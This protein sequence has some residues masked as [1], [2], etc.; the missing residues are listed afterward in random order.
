MELCNSFQA[1]FANFTTVFSASSFALWTAL[2]AG[3]IQSHRHRFVSDLI[4]SSDSTRNGTWT[5]YYHFFSRNK[6]SLPN[7]C[8][9]LFLLIVDRLIPQDAV[10]VLA[11]DDTLCRKRGLGIFGVGMHHDPLIS[12]KN[13][14]LT[15]WGHNWVIV[16]VIVSGLPWAPNQVWSLPI[17]FRLYV[18]KQGNVKGKSK[19][20]NKN[21]DPNHKTR[22]P[23]AVELLE[24]IAEWLPERT[25]V[26]CGDSLYGGKSVVQNLPANMHQISRLPLTAALYEVA[27]PKPKGQRGP[28]RKKGE[29]LPSIDAW[30]DDPRTPWTMYNFDIYGLHTKLRFKC[31]DA[32][33]YGVGKDRLMRIIVVEDLQGKRGRQAF[34]CTNPQWNVRYILTCYAQ[35]WSIEVAFEN[36][37]QLMGFADPANRKL[38][39]VE[40]TAPMAFVLYGLIVIWF[41]EHGHRHVE[42]PHRPWYPQKRT[43]SFGD[44]LT[45]LRR[46]SWE[47]KTA[48][49]LPE[50]GAL[51]DAVDQMT[52]FLSLAG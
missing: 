48:D 30:A 31:Q 46:L 10:L 36:G 26:V 9:R 1:Y 16:S 34:F 20:K 21:Q 39:A 3:W 18:N 42:F 8:Q 15:S 17:G 49:L 33:Y 35:R 12:S 45:T 40:R 32:L 50:Q 28:Q 4:V 11:V 51:K 52:Y 25:F 41:H 43:P 47:E 24:M 23:L 6:W 5:K 7:L 38:Q 44:M 22:P 19:N 14:K 37:K 2:S 29:R 13:K 27:P